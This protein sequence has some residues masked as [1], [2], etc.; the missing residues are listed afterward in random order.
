M[1]FYVNK[2]YFILLMLDMRTSAIT[3]YGHILTPYTV[4]TEVQDMRSAGCV[5]AMR[6]GKSVQGFIVLT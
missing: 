5:T 1:C 3:E 4:V 6:E 2:I